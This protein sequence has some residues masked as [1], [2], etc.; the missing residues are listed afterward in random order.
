MPPSHPQRLCRPLL[1]PLKLR[2]LLWVDSVG[3]ALI[4]ELPC[5]VEGPHATTDLPASQE[6]CT[7]L[8]CE[9]AAAARP[10][11][12]E[13]TL[14]PQQIL[15]LLALPTGS[16]A[17]FLQPWAW[18]G[19][20]HSP[21]APPTGSCSSKE[22]AAVAC[23]ACAPSDGSRRHRTHGDCLSPQ[24]LLGLHPSPPLQHLPLMS[25]ETKKKMVQWGKLFDIWNKKLE[26]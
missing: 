18:E 22:V 26:Y 11:T 6:Q 20:P 13:A 8:A 14:A 25:Q 7:W 9:V 5:W 10:P 24:A 17:S 3:P 15:S 23:L 19:L 1:P 16:S 21:P 4:P 2:S 12:D